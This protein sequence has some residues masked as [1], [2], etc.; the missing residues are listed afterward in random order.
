MIFRYNPRA[1]SLQFR[2]TAFVCQGREQNQGTP[3]NANGEKYEPGNISERKEGESKK[4][5]EANEKVRTLRVSKGMMEML[6][7]PGKEGG[8]KSAQE[9]NGLKRDQEVEGCCPRITRFAGRG[10][11]T[12]P[13]TLIRI[14]VEFFCYLRNF[15]TSSFV[16]KFHGT[17]SN[18][19]Y[20]RAIEMGETTIT[21]ARVPGEKIIQQ[22]DR[23]KVSSKVR[24][25]SARGDRGARTKA[26]NR[27]TRRNG[28]ERGGYRED[29]SKRGVCTFIIKRA[30]LWFSECENIRAASELCEISVHRQ[31][32][33]TPF[34]LPVFHLR[35]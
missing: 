30:C 4:K 26:R 8:E 6:T 27:E 16:R 3:C 10:L 28:G 34:L 7:G 35:R 20:G 2:Q 13:T 22:L 12:Q 32:F 31:F 21:R 24:R 1:R 9:L 19:S 25:K 5:K 33:F 29:E 23:D 15:D 14:S 11:C 17:V 18:N